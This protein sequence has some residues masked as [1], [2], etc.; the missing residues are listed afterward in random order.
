VAKRPEPIPDRAPAD[1][2]D[3]LARL[4]VDPEDLAAFCKRQ[5]IVEMGVS[6]DVLGPDFG[7]KSEVDVVVRYA[8]RRD[9]EFREVLEMTRELGRLF[10]REVDIIDRSLV[11]QTDDQARRQSVLG[12]LRDIYPG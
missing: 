1:E 12:D 2:R 10:G 7:P 4:G 11:D 6:G 3:P 9:P 5:G 8:A